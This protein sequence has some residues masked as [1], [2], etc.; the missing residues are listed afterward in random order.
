[1]T[2]V[3]EAETLG[4]QGKMVNLTARADITR[5]FW[6]PLEAVAEGFRRDELESKPVQGGQ[7]WLATG[8]KAG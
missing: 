3:K 4:F 1:M 2:D 7:M 6:E 5:R 8:V